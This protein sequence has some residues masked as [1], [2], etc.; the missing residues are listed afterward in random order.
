MEYILFKAISWCA[1]V[2]AGGLTYLISKPFIGKMHASF[3]A[4][5]IGTASMAI[6]LFF[7]ERKASRP[8]EFIGPGI[9]FAI[10]LGAMIFAWYKVAN[11]SSI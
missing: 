10:M 7:N 11:V 8:D 9:L 6:A 5:I 1:F 4:L 2:A 3:L